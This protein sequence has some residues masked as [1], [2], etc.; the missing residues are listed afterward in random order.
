MNSATK[1]AEATVDLLSLFL[2]PK[3]GLPTVAL[4]LSLTLMSALTATAFEYMTTLGYD[5][6]KQNL[7][8]LMSS[9]PAIVCVSLVP[10]LRSLV[11]GRDGPNTF[12][13]LN[14]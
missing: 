2:D 14:V 8:W 3:I 4:F 12:E 10:M 13:R 7:T 11:A 9:I 6:V 1:E 5:H